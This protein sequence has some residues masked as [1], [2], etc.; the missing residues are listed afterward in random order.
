MSY[1]FP[2]PGRPTWGVFVHSRL[3]ALARR[4]ELEVAAPR[5][6]FPV[7]S[8]LRGL[9]PLRADLDGL[10]VHYPRWFYLPGLCKRLDGRLYARGVRRWLDEY[11]RNSA[12]D[13][14]DVHFVWP[15][16]VAA[17]H[18]ARRAGLPLVITLRG[19]LYPC[20]DRPELRR[21]ALAALHAADAIVSVSRPLAEA[22]VDAGIAREKIIVIPNGVDGD[23]FRPRDRDIARRELGLG[24][25]VPVLVTVAHLGPRKGHLETLRALAKLPGDVRLVLVGDCPAG[26]RNRRKLQEL[27]T[28]LGV[29]DRVTFAGRQDRRRV[30]LYFN[31]ADVS[32]LASHR[33]GCPN[34]VLESLASGTPVVATDVGAVRDILPRQAGRIVPVRDADALACGIEDVLG[35]ELSAEEVRGAA[36]P[37]SWDDVARRVE[38][39]FG[40]VLAEREVAAGERAGAADL[41]A[42]TPPDG[43]EQEDGGE[44]NR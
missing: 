2:D 38:E 13:L 41:A 9:P 36:A 16:G 32:V 23:T 37:A 29:Q 19:W 39:V 4:V 26:G 24:L 40:N 44:G 42:A 14:L 27:A 12:P 28:R 11:C 31:S 17:M 15:D 22:A 1:C 33:E 3:A 35:R 25:D 10:S 7:V 6:V 8:R 43:A 30:A 21:Q 18:L 34:T 20:L 5:P